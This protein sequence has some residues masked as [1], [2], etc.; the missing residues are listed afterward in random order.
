VIEEVQRLH[1]EPQSFTTYRRNHLKT[2][3]RRFFDSWAEALADAKL[4]PS[5][6]QIMHTLQDQFIRGRSLED[7]RQQDPGLDAAA[8]KTFGSWKKAVRAAGLREDR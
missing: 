7:L 2:V 3:A 1:G 4:I 6:E 8:R 5:R